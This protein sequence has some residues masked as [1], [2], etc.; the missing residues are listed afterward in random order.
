[1]NKVS[2]FLVVAFL[3]VA[4]LSIAQCNTNVLHYYPFT[5]NSF[6]DA[7]G[8]ND[9]VGYGISPDVGRFNINLSA[10][11]SNNGGNFMDIE[12]VS[13]NEIS[14]SMW[15]MRLSSAPTV[16]ES[17][18]INDDA[19]SGNNSHLVLDNQFSR[20]GIK[21][22]GTFISANSNGIIPRDEQWYHVVF[23]A[24]PGYNYIYVNGV[25]A[26]NY[27]AAD[28]LDLNEYPISRFFNHGTPGFTQGWQGGIDDIHLINKVLNPD[29][30][31][32]MRG[33]QNHNILNNFDFPCINVDRSFGPNYLG[34]VDPSL[35]THQW[36]KD[37]VAV[38]GQ[39]ERTFALT[40]VQS[41]D[42]G[43]YQ[44]FATMNCIT[45]TSN[46]IN[47]TV[48]TNTPP[49]FTTQPQDITTCEGE[50]VNVNVDVEHATS[51]QWYKDNQ[52][53]SSI[54]FPSWVYPSIPAEGAGEYFLRAQNSCG[55]VETDRI[56][57]S[58]TPATV[59]T[60]QPLASQTLCANETLTLEA[61]ATGSNVTYQW[62]KD[63]INVFGANG[64]ILTINNFNSS[65]AGNYT[66]EI[67]G[68][69]GGVLTTST[70][71]VQFNSLPSFTQ[72]PNGA[73][74]CQGDEVNIIATA[75]NAD[76]YQWYFEG[77]EL[78][79]INFPGFNFPNLQP[80]N[81]GDYVLE[82][83]N[84][85]GT[86]TSNA[87]TVLVNT[88]QAEF[89]QQPQT[90]VFCSGGGFSLNAET[91]NAVS[92]QWLLNGN[93]VSGA[94]TN[95]Y[96]VA[97]AGSTDEGTYVLEATDL[98]G[99]KSQSNS[100]LVGEAGMIHHYPLDNLS[101]SDIVGG[102]DILSLVDIF[103]STNRFGEANKAVAF[104]QSALEV[105]PISTDKLSVSMWIR[106]QF[107]TFSGVS[108]L[109]SSNNVFSSL[110]HLLVDN[111]NNRIGF[112]NG[113]VVTSASPAGTIN[114][115]EWTHVVWTADGAN[116]K[117]YVNGTLA[118]STSNGV[119]PALEPILR[120]GTG[121]SS[122][123]GWTGG[124]DDIKIYNI[125]LS[126]E[127]AKL[128]YGLQ[129]LPDLVQL[130]CANPA[131]E[132]T[133][134]PSATA[135]NNLEYQWFFNGNSMNGQTN[136]SLI[137]PTIAASSAGDYK[138]AVNIQ[139]SCIAEQ[140]NITT[141][142]VD[143]TGLID[144][145]SQ[146][147]DATA[148]EGSNHLFSVFATGDIS[149][150]QWRKNG[151]NIPGAVNDTYFLTGAATND[152]GNYDVQITGACGT[153]TS[154][155]VEFD[156]EYAPSIVTDIF[157]TSACTGESVD[158]PLIVEGED[159]VFEWNK[160]GVTLPGGF[161]STYTIP[162]VTLADA[163][164][165]QAEI[166]N[167]CGS[168][169]SNAAP[170]SV[171][172][173]ATINIQP[174]GGTICEGNDFTLTCIP[175]GG[176]TV[177]SFKWLKDGVELPGASTLNYTLSNMTPEQSGS[178]QMEI[179][180][181]CGSTLLS[182]VAEIIVNPATVINDVNINAACIG[183]SVSL[184]ASASGQ[185]LSYQWSFDGSILTG[186]TGSSI[187]I[188]SASAV[189]QGDYTIEVAGTCGTVVSDPLT[190]TLNDVPSFDVTPS[191]GVYCQGEEVDLS[192]Q[193]TN[194]P[195]S[196][197]WLNEGVDVQN[198]G[199]EILIFD[200]ILP[201]DAG[202]Y[203]IIATN[204]CGS[205]NSSTFSIVV[206][207]TFEQTITETLCFG[208]V[209]TIN[210]VD[211]EEEGEYTIVLSTSE[212]CDSTIFLELAVLPEIT[213]QVA[214]TICEG[215]SF[216]FGTQTITAAG[217]Y[218]EIFPAQSLCDSTVTLTLEVIDPSVSFPAVQTI[219]FGESFE[220]GTQ[221]L[222]ES[223][224]FT[225]TFT[226]TYGCDSTVVLDLAVENEIDVTLNIN[227]GVAAVSSIAG[228]NY[229]WIDCDNGNNPI[230]GATT[231]TFAPEASGN[232]AVIVTLND[233]DATSE[234]TFVQAAGVG[235]KHEVLQ[236]IKLFPNPATT[237]I[238]IAEI[239]Q[240]STIT[241]TD[242]NGRVMFTTF[243][244]E[245]SLEVTLE[246]YASG[247]Y[248]VNVVNEQLNVTQKLIVK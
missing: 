32:F 64:S 140:S 175:S 92:L 56:N 245:T 1:M 247:V 183:E 81:A 43:M 24:G 44:L 70:A 176:G 108:T 162:S 216:E 4:Q 69:C 71:N 65:Q 50:D 101:G 67:E 3:G 198:T 122:N 45:L 219:C 241:I 73:E 62:K 194:N 75:V 240:P 111:T 154:D 98:N 116:N 38:N 231:N 77:Q 161:S 211:Y 125:T 196:V 5:N 18:L 206:N 66:C 27:T 228:A 22:N 179:I 210:N 58:V 128:M 127:E 106:R 11:R 97:L 157:L 40:P 115:N 131:L 99:C 110:T 242:V 221:T 171:S 53:M 68:D 187:S 138:V 63:G 235:T 124:I 49:I 229:Q 93:P 205:T 199:S 82:A 204:E 217:E 139:G 100:I 17:F 88:P 243:A 213:N 118:L 42:A 232:Y 85:C 149:A 132:L 167:F 141:V 113:S 54:T 60:Q 200:A 201:S 164:N 226:A 87:A 214:A 197:Q 16:G 105:N 192:A 142:Q 2:A 172:Q 134:N 238:T 191:A 114:F 165:Y 148:C 23:S 109:L 155:L 218:V 173:E 195:T 166:S 57:I 78:T 12:D 137:I 89:T 20:L 9:A 96:S 102:N 126:D 129:P 189:N 123:N 144:I 8:T 59:I 202:D 13:G 237:S 7:S 186:A 151:V 227:E 14:V 52:V 10:K 34:S 222:T 158:F 31:Q 120:F 26:L 236:T 225:E 79:G 90:P 72:E 143:A 30:V 163:G 47:I 152:I 248:L 36:F 159:L 147:N 21:V 207:P 190:L 107:Y 174:V 80:T 244:N 177:A 39:D 180:S 184:S 223:G 169:T 33:F 145:T 182:N 153:V 239:S 37:G 133:A 246:N 74:V 150:Y 117:I 188:A 46:E 170:L 95:T 91:D 212:G 103:N 112:R 135:L 193:I 234:C 136:Q 121:L 19:D 146:P 25:L 94:T 83:T 55:T 220:F 178:Y 209:Y 84:S 6:A 35:V 86:V 61:A 215:E 41:S 76:T 160:D 28:A 156:L 203:E 230:V 233:C 119:N 208:E 51:Y 29:E 130:D 15:V 224:T 48:G 185:N 104:D 168:V 181:T